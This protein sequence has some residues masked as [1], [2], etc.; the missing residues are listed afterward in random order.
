MDRRRIT[1][2]AVTLAIAFGTGYVM[3]NGSTIG[4]RLNETPQQVTPTP[5][6]TVAEE[7][8]AALPELPSDVVVPRLGEQHDTM[9]LRRMTGLDRA[10]HVPGLLDAQTPAPFELVGIAG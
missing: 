6:E 10:T 2:V 4:A 3:Q 7:E 1:N 5:N 8:K 9:Q